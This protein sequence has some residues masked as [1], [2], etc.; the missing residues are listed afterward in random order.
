MPAARLHVSRCDRLQH[1]EHEQGAVYPAND[2][3]EHG[4]PQAI[5]EADKRRLV[6]GDVVISF[7]N[8]IVDSVQSEV[9][10]DCFHA[11]TQLFDFRL[12]RSGLIE[13]PS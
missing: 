1:N 11:L 8:W 13:L 12:Q 6:K 5:A 7:Q 10:L 4:G 9:A 2:G 3:I